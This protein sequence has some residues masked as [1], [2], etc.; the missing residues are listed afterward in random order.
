MFLTSEVLRIKEILCRGDE[1]HKP[2]YGPYWLISLR[3]LNRIIT[4]LYQDICEIL[5][6]IDKILEIAC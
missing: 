6:P 3:D 2:W 1:I 5:E 4:I